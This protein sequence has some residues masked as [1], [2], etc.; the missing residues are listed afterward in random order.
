MASISSDCGFQFKVDFSTISD[1]QLRR[2]FASRS[3]EDL[4]LDLDFTEVLHLNMNF[5]YN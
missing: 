3:Y 2:V 4:Q 5:S 1:Q